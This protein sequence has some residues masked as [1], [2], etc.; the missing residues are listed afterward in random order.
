MHRFLIEYASL[1]KGWA[2]GLDDRGNNQDRRNFFISYTRSDRQWA[3]WIAMQLEEAGYT[4]FIQAWD[5]RPGSNFVAEMDNA[6]K[7]AERTLLVLSPAY[8]ES[9]F[10]FAEWAAAFR[11]DLKGTHRRLLPV[12]IQPVDV[13]GLLGPVVFIDLVQL[14]EAEARERLLAGIQQGRVKPTM[15]AFPGHYESLQ[16]FAFPGSLPPIW[17]IPFARNPF[18]TGRNDLL[19]HLHTH[20][21][22]TQAAALSQPQA[23]CGL[24]GIGK[25]QLAIEYSYR[26]RQNYQAVLWARADTTEALNASYTEL[27]RLLQLPPRDAQEQ[28]VIVQAVKGWLRTHEDWLLILDNADELDLVQTFLPTA[29]PGHLLLTTRAQTMG[30]LARRLEVETLDTAVGALFLLRRAGLVAS[31]ASLETASPSDRALANVLTEELGGLPLALDQAGAYIE[32]T[33]CSLADYQQQYQTRRGELLAHRGMLVDDHPEPVA[34]TWSLSFAKVEAANPTA[35]EVLRICAFL[36]PDAI[37]EELLMEALKT[38]LPTSRA[39]KKQRGPGGWFSWLTLRSHQQTN[40]PPLEKLSKEL[41]EAIAVLR[42]YSFL[43][44]QIAEPAVRVHQLV[45]AVLRDSMSAKIQ[46]QWM[47]RTISAVAHTYPEKTAFGLDFNQWPALERLLPHALRCATWI[48]QAKIKNPASVQLLEQ[49]GSYL[50]ARV[51]YHEAEPLLQYALSICGKQSGTDR[52]DELRILEKLALLYGNQGK[53]TES[54]KWFLDAIS[55]CEDYYGSDH[56]EVAQ[57]CTNLAEMYR[58]HGMFAAAHTLLERAVS[59]YTHLS[60]TN[61]ASLLVNALTILALLHWDQFQFTKAE[62]FLQRA[63][64]L[65]RQFQ[66][67]PLSSVKVLNSLGMLYLNQGKYSEA[68]KLFQETLNICIQQFPSQSLYSIVCHNNLAE[69]SRARG[70]HKKAEALFQQALYDC[71]ALFGE[72]HLY[73]ALCLNNLAGLY[74]GQNQ[75]VEAE[76]LYER[77]LAIRRK[78]QLDDGHS[79]IVQS[80]NNLAMLLLSRGKFQEAESLSQNA[81]TIYQEQWGPNHL[82]TVLFLNNL[83]AVYRFQK[84]YNEAEPLEKHALTIVEAQLGRDHFYAAMLLNNIAELSHAQ[85]NAREAQQYAYRLQ[86]II[87]ELAKS[88]SPSMDIG[89]TTWAGLR[90]DQS[91]DWNPKPQHLLII[92]EQPWG[93]IFQTHV[94]ALTT[95]SASVTG[96]AWK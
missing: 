56:P 16:P 13:D 61:Y 65:H 43:E 41:R 67:E 34:T 93:P 1:L 72:D 39:S 50:D 37:P 21:H 75:Y 14:E 35:A 42:S 91:S 38:P 74:V 85:S 83:A 62:Q 66:M 9:D 8:L 48:K 47:Q 45:Q 58:E 29:C 89:L 64:T 32:E 4:L 80:M 28:E 88:E 86:I 53:F 11:S 36:A 52:S 55:R 82:Y 54:E 51:R 95:W 81:L 84:N 5:F 57:K 33:Q 79:D 7:R 63:F 2:M 19:E 76:P 15:V 26:Y 59:I 30:K 73:V 40:P 87:E 68:E 71:E 69:L 27:A 22:T 23:I 78:Q 46:Q 94:R 12:R 70:E 44:R 77:A 92:R 90:L 10:A 60:R 3:E 6:S 25:T 31:N 18:F 24:G 49:A 20:L 96:V 17:N